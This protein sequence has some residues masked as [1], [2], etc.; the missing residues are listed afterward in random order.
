[1]AGTNAHL[2]GVKVPLVIRRRQKRPRA[3]PFGAPLRRGAGGGGAETPRS[4]AGL[5]L[6][7]R[8]R[9]GPASGE[10]HR[11]LSL[12]S[13]QRACLSLAPQRWTAK[14]TR[15]A[16]A[17]RNCYCGDLRCFFPRRGFVICSH[18]YHAPPH[19][20]PL[21]SKFRPDRPPPLC[22]T[23]LAGSTRQGA[24]REKRR[25]SMAKMLVLTL[26]VVRLLLH[27]GIG[28]EESV[29]EEV[30]FSALFVCR[31]SCKCWLF[32]NRRPQTRLEIQ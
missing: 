30:G 12:A 19:L 17:T 26:L 13:H 31:L 32:G 8:R 11:L 3:A 27:G 10:V 25:D 5:R 15:R 20:S 28:A 29:A 22:V 18:V 1:M 6:P 2:E 14:S 24:G 23:E 21:I 16:L 7:G 4:G 9:H